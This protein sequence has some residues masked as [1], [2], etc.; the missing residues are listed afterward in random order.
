MKVAPSV[1]GLFSANASGSGPGAILNQ[2]TTPNSAANPAVAGSVIVMFGTG[3]GLTT[4]PSTDGQ[5]NTPALLPQPSLPISVTIGGITAHINYYGAMPD[6][7][8][9]LF[10]L[11]VVVPA[12]LTAGNQPVSVLI[13]T[14]S[15]QANLSVAVH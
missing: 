14:A 5:I 3:E 2:D 10:Q 11:N 7:V 1:P 8:A 15:S 12:G 13:G 9:G 6:E 4:P